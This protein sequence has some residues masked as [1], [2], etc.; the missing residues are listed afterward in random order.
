MG[1]G[2]K[3]DPSRGDPCGRGVRAV[4][5]EVGVPESL[6]SG[7]TLRTGK[8]VEGTCQARRTRAKEAVTM[9]VVWGGNTLA[10]VRDVRARGFL[11]LGLPYVSIAEVYSGGGGLNGK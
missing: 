9:Q 7:R 4:R 3:H 6:W 2:S 8:C 1:N 5:V 11:Q 10:N